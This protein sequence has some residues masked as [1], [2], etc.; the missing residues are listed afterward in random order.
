[1]TKENIKNVLTEMLE[2][3]FTIEE[4]ADVFGWINDYLNAKKK[5][6]CMEEDEEYRR[7]HAKR[8]PLFRKWAEE[9]LAN[10]GLN[11][12]IEDIEE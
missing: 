7:A 3:E 11:Y 6:N 8:I 2:R 12:T 10:Y 4:I 5:A 1:M 9:A